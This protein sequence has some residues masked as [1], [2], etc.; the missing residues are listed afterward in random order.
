MLRR[1]SGVL[2]ASV[3]GL[4][5]PV[6]ALATAVVFDKD[7]DVQSAVAPATPTPVA[8]RQRIGVGARVST[9][10]GK[11]VLRFDDGL[12]V[13]L[14]ADTTLRIVDYRYSEKDP[15]SP[16]NRVVLELERGAVR[17]VT[18]WMAHVNAA[19]FTLRAPQATL[20][21]REGA[22]FTVALVNPMYVAVN[23]GSVV[24]AN[25]AGKLALAEGS[26]IVVASANADTVSPSGKWVM[27]ITCLFSRVQ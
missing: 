24:T 13:A 11:A 23:V 1:L 9:S 8:E 15:W 10:A 16:D 5:C 25:A 6:A 26:R 21:V 12:Q 18:G 14:A 2:A 20:T 7:G 22:D 19:S 3:L 27:T 17:V 4:A